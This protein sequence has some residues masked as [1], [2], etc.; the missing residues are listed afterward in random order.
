M[1]DGGDRLRVR[2]DQQTIIPAVIMTL[3]FQDLALA[4]NATRHAHAG[5]AGFG[6][7]IGEPYLVHMRQHVDHQFGDFDLDLKRGGEMGAARNL[8]LHNLHDL[9]MRMT[10]RQAAKGKLPV[11]I[12]VAVHIP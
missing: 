3:E 1:A 11:D 6:P 8:F 9:R 2:A 10:Q 12:F 4:G 7:G 5:H